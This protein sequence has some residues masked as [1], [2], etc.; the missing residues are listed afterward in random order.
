M[1]QF[2]PCNLREKWHLFFLGIAIEDFNDYQYLEII[3]EVHSP[4]LTLMNMFHSIPGHGTETSP[5]LFLCNC[6]LKTKQ[7]VS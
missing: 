7:I 4:I 3:H 5:K 2:L 1:F 6:F